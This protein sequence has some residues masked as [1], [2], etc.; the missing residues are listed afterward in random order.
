MCVFSYYYFFLGYSKVDATSFPF[1][2]SHWHNTVVGRA[3]DWTGM[4][5]HFLNWECLAD[6]KIGRERYAD[7]KRSLYPESSGVFFCFFFP[8]L[9]LGKSTSGE[10]EHQGKQGFNLPQPYS[11]H[12]SYFAF[13]KLSEI[14]KG[15]TKLPPLLSS[16]TKQNH[17]IMDLRMGKTFKIECNCRYNGC[18]LL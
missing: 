18:L 11:F 10:K 1:C 17:K 7:F 4:Q 2:E 5:F 9:A 8:L 15:R 6:E 12:W 16:A 3:Q 13:P 14:L